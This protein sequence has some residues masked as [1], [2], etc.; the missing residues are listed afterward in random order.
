VNKLKALIFDL[1]GTLADTLPLCLKSFQDSIEKSTGTRPSKEQVERFWGYS[2]HGIIK[3]LDKKTP[4][5]SFEIWK[6]T[7]KTLHVDYCNLFEGIFP[8]LEWLKKQGILLFLVTGK[9]DVSCSI[10]LEELKIENFFDEV[11]TGSEKGSIKP[12]CIE[13]LMQKYNLASDEVFY[14][15]D[16]P[17][18]VSD[19]KSVGV[20]TISACWAKSAN[21]DAVIKEKPYKICYSV[22]EF[23]ELVEG[24]FCNSVTANQ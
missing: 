12:E 15:G 14:V 6:N 4:E 5:K 22:E 7:Y 17:S 21:I 1:D 19:A 18:D 23:I 10:T 8:L 9:G 13:E 16:A 3:N 24:L 11:K 20:D 2:E